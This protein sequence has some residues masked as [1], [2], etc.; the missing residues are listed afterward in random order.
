MVVAVHY[1]CF[2]IFQ[3]E[4]ASASFD[5]TKEDAGDV[6]GG[7]QDAKNA[8]ITQDA[9]NSQ[10]PQS[11]EHQTGDEVLERGQ[12]GKPGGAH[13]LLDWL[14]TVGAWRR[15]WPS[16]AKLRLEDAGPAAYGHAE[17]AV[18]AR[19]AAVAGL[20]QLTTLPLELAQIVY[21]LS[22]HSL[23]WRAIT[24]H[25][26]CLRALWRRQ[27][28]QQQQLTEPLRL[29][30]LAKI[31]SWE[32]GHALH[33][34]DSSSALSLSL[35]PPLIRI[36]VDRVGICRIE[37]RHEIAARPWNGATTTRLAFIVEDARIL[38]SLPFADIQGFPIWNL[39]LPPDPA[40]CT[41]VGTTSFRRVLELRR[42]PPSQLYA[43][44]VNR[45]F[46]LTF[47]YLSGRISGVH[48][49][50]TAKDDARKTYERLATRVK[51]RMVW[52]F[53]P[54]GLDD[55]IVALWA[56]QCD[57]S[58]N[59][60]ARM[61]LAGDVMIGRARKGSFRTMLLAQGDHIMFVYG[62]PFE[63]KA[64]EILG[65]YSGK[66]QP[67]EESHCITQSVVPAV[68]SAI[69]T[70]FPD[71]YVSSAPLSDV[72]AVR[73]FTDKVKGICRGLLLWYGNGGVRAL[74]ECRICVDESLL[75]KSPAVICY[76]KLRYRAYRYASHDGV[77]VDA[78]GATQHHHAEDGWTCHEVGRGT[79]HFHF[80]TNRS[81]VMAYE[82]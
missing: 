10:V 61:T 47:F 28:Q 21:E 74:G 82:Q 31:L 43:V 32:R 12:N 40:S 72:K 44:D 54:I 60:V 15:P 57:G 66:V 69:S 22:A 67:R 5:G 51:E 68:P 19:M 4:S 17:L 9:Q 42:P 2:R 70:Q 46:G 55:R 71:T 11:D 64:V 29:V 52:V 35:L 53:L 79:L 27:Q 13:A 78:G 41:L 58:F 25:C 14:W 56:C 8:K 39:S 45:C 33:V 38:A 37:R 62:E 49:H 23:F 20:V 34:A 26:L 75:V 3:A 81:F 7:T 77:V 36:T 80:T 73:V 76:R 63:S 24:V 1:D 18:F 48:V 30:P 6:G 59:I 50:R 65:A 16:A